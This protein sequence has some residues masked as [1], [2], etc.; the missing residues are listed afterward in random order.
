MDRA[1]RPDAPGPAN[2]AMAVS[3]LGDGATN[4]GVIHEAM[5]MAALWKIPAVYFIEN[6]LY[7]VATSVKE[8][9][10]VERLAQCGL[11]HGIGGSS[12]TAWIPSRFPSPCGGPGRRRSLRHRG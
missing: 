2:P 11:S 4:Q 3:F 6:N 8:A 12:W 1:A 9:C 5:N 10:A 7:A